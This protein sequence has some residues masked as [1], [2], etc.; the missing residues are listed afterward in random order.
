MNKA[1]FPVVAAGAVVLGL[2]FR[3]AWLD[4]RPMHHD[5]ANQAVRFGQLLEAGE[6]RYDRNDHHGPTLYYLTLP[7]AWA[8]GQ[9]TLASLDERTLRIV[10]AAFGVGLILLL[11]LTARGLGRVAAAAGA[12]LAAL[13]PALTY[14]SRFYIQESV[15]LFFVVG[16]LIA[17][18]R[19]AVGGGAAAVVAAGV[20]AGL[21]LATKETATP[22]LIAAVVSCAA[23]RVWTSGRRGAEG[24]PESPPHGRPWPPIRVAHVVGALVV[25][26][27]VAVTLYSSFFTSLS[28]VVDAVRAFGVYARRGVAPGTHGEPWDYYLRLLG[29]SSSGGLVWTEGLVLALALAGAVFAWPK[30]SGGFWPRYICLYSAITLVAFSLVRY[31]TPWNLLPFYGGSVALA[32]FGAAALLGVM[33]SRV[34][35]GLLVAALLATAAQLGLQSWRANFRYPAD[36]RNPYVY[37]QTSPDFLRLV[38]RVA[39]VSAVHPDRER[40]LVAVVTGPYEQWPLPWYL[41]RM[42]RVGY[43]TTAGAVGPLDRMPLIIASADF[44]GGVEAALGDRYVSEFYGLRP[45]VLLTVF[46]ERRLWDQFLASKGSGRITDQAKGSGRITDQGP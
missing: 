11:A 9:T 15:L 39:G 6:Y 10:P 19:Y 20:C 4:L 38:A 5:E 34:S 25:A 13:S 24:P 28:G 35:R 7:V 41:R 16:F 18:G 21:A 32:G 45:G 22:I 29:Y 2:A 1:V 44:A 46:I 36:Q 23:A 33:R 14:F 12:L 43:W 27:L 3:L 40:M 17:L 8:R 31:K 26:M 37:A 42:P 30:R